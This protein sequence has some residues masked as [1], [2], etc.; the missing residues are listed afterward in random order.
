MNLQKCNKNICIPYEHMHAPNF[1]IVKIS[2]APET[3]FKS[4]LM[5]VGTGQFQY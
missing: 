5:L 1:G 4:I 2:A 3:Y